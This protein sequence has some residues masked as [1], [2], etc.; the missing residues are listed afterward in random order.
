MFFVNNSFTLLNFIHLAVLWQFLFS[1]IVPFYSC[2]PCSFLSQSFI[3]F[4]G[5]RSENQ[6]KS[7]NVRAQAFS[8]GIRPFIYGALPFRH[9]RFAVSALSFRRLG[10]ARSI[11]RFLNSAKEIPKCMYLALKLWFF[12]SNY[13]YDY[14]SPDWS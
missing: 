9:S 4:L 12:K 2:H 6:N 5:S 13:F 7:A 11:L 10:P 3:I 8:S 14:F 1:L